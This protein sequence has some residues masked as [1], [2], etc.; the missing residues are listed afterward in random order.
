MFADHRRE[1]G[2]AVSARETFDALSSEFELYTVSPEQVRPV[3]WFWKGYFPSGK[4]AIVSGRP[5]VNKSTMLT[6]VVARYTRGLPF[7]DGTASSG[8]GSVVWVSKEEDPDDTITP[9]FLLHGGDWERL[10]YVRR[11]GPSSH[12]A[13]TLPDDVPLFEAAIEQARAGLIVFD[14]LDSFYSR[15]V[16][17][18]QG[19]DIRHTLDPLAK[20][21]QRLDVVAIVI[22]HHTK[23]ATDPLQALSGSGQLGAAPRAVWSVYPAADEPSRRV[24]AMA[25]LS[26]GKPGR[27]LSFRVSDSGQ[28][29]PA[30]TWEGPTDET[31][32]DLLAAQ[33]PEGK[34]EGRA[35]E[36]LRQRLARGPVASNAL[37]R[38]AEAVGISWATLKRAQ[39]RLH[40]SVRKLSKAEDLKQSWVWSLSEREE[41]DDDDETDERD[42][43]DGHQLSQLTHLSNTPP[44]SKLVNGVSQ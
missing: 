15:E 18:N 41:R 28:D 14:A 26:V 9:R 25:K 6:D 5:G 27:N 43:R 35:V 29:L 10:Q 13:F 12:R 22:H 36:F 31:A 11:T 38:E 32:A 4:L 33:A 17:S 20:V 39:A 7:P 21:A 37:R 42:G 24:F 16:N 2:G 19:K 34:A 40:L 1:E 3:R 30:I 23:G 44:L 8:P